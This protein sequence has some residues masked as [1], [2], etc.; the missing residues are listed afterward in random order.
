MANTPWRRRNIKLEVDT[1]LELTEAGTV[2]GGAPGAGKG[3]VWV[4][5]DAPNVLMFTDDTGIDTVLGGGGGGEQ[6]L[7][8][9][10]YQ[11]LV[12]YVDPGDR[13]SYPVTGSVVNDIMGNGTSGTLTTATLADNG[14]RFNGTSGSVAFTKNASIDHLFDGGGTLIVFVRPQGLGEASAGII[15]GTAPSVGAASAG[16]T[17]NVESTLS[18]RCTFSFLQNFS[19]TGSGGRWV[20]YDQTSKTDPTP[21]NTYAGAR[22]LP[23]S[24]YSSIAITYNSSAT[25]NDPTFYINGITRTTTLGIQEANT[26]VGTANTDTGQ[27]VTIGNRPADDRTFNGDIGPVLMFDRILTPT[28]ITQVV[29]T[30]VHRYGAGIMAATAAQQRNAQGMVIKSGDFSWVGAGGNDQMTGGHIA[31]IAGS[32][33]IDN[34]GSSRGASTLIKGGDNIGN[35]GPIAGGDV[36]IRGGNASTITSSQGGRF[37]IQGGASGNSQFSTASSYIAG[38]DAP[39]AGNGPQTLA[40]RAGVCTHSSFAGTNGA[41]ILRTGASPS[42]TA[43]ISTGQLYISTGTS[44]GITTDPF[45]TL[46]NTNSPTGPITITTGPTGANATVSGA[47]QISTGAT[48][49]TST[50]GSGALSITTGANTATSNVAT[51]GSITIATGNSSGLNFA[52]GAGNVNIT[53]GNQTNTGSAANS[54]AGSVIITGGNNAATNTA[55]AGSV[56]VQAGN[57]TGTNTFG[58]SATLRSG[59]ASGVNSGATVTVQSGNGGATGGGGL[60]QI[61]AGNGGATSGVGGE[62]VIQGGNATS[63]VGGSISLAPGAGSGGG[64]GLGTVIIGGSCGLQFSERGTMPGAAITGGNG[65]LWV[66]NETPNALIFTDDTGVDTKLGSPWPEG[67]VT[68]NL[69]FVVDATNPNCDN[70]ASN[71]VRNMKYGNSNTAVGNYTGN[72]TFSFGAWEFDGISGDINFANDAVL[73]DPFAGGGTI[74]AWIRPSSDGETDN[75]RILSKENTGSTGWSLFTAGED[76][77]TG[78][79]DIQFLVR[80]TGTLW[81]WRVNDVGQSIDTWSCII[82]RYDSNNVSTAPRIWING[83][84]QDVVV[85]TTGSGTYASDAANNIRIGNRQGDDRTFHGLI[86]FT[87]IWDTELDDK[88]IKRLYSTTRPKFMPEDDEIIDVLEVSS[89]VQE[90]TLGGLSSENDGYYRLTGRGITTVGATDWSWEPNTISTNQGG[91]Y[92]YFEGGTVT[93]GT[94][95]SLEFINFY[96]DGEGANYFRG[97]F[98]VYIWP[99]HTRGGVAMERMYQ[100]QASVNDGTV[101]SGA[102]AQSFYGLWDD[103]ATNFTEM[104]IFASAANGIGAG[105]KFVLRRYSDRS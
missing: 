3:K 101:A 25:T 66:R 41:L 103:T 38:G 55:F 12:F 104:T 14:F 22:A 42:G 72:T 90:L 48:A 93:G 85:V 105:S 65:R 87:G 7:P 64:S 37:I 58:G 73:D 84:E 43:A 16:W 102:V 17:L 96:T 89:A 9:N 30:F 86:G 51:S 8:G 100:S 95:S 32:T 97:I 47:I 36:I 83:I 49:T 76:A 71:T 39:L 82:L 13:D 57:G 92:T 67:I 23:F 5:S 27:P 1:T 74:M 53:G 33:F 19:G 40:I 35:I 52:T 80:T 6:G 31:I 28:E 70:G 78:Q 68:E 15:V 24:A 10:V 62:V 18:E 21:L 2:P 98:D 4:R 91:R 46:G 88:T 69:L 81:Q 34:I 29:N 26:P 50:G 60:V 59:N 77:T 61:I 94:I 11:N 99:A 79:I 54:V 45:G 44:T 20:A 63:G 56:T 75:G